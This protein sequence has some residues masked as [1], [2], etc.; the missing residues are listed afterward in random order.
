MINYWLGQLIVFVVFS[1]CALLCL[2]GVEN[3]QITKPVIFVGGY[4][5][6]VLT[7]RII[8]YLE[9]KN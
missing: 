2:L 3:W 6:G 7:F 1:V 8:E 5:S 4:F 9:R